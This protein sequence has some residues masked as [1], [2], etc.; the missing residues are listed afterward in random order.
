[1]SRAAQLATAGALLCGLAVLFA[2]SA[3]Y[4]PGVALLLVAVFA[5]VW[6]RLAAARASV[7]LDRAVASAYEGERIAVAICVRRG[8]LPFGPAELLVGELPV[9][10]PSGPE[11]A[12][13]TV[14]AIAARRGRQA[15]GPAR[16]R[17]GDPLGICVRELRSQEHELLVLPRVYPVGAGVLDR[18]QRGGSHAM[19]AD[20]QLHLDSLRA[21]DASGPASRIHWPT[22]ART[23]ELMSR[24]FAAEAD[25]RVLVVLDARVPA[26]ED[27]LD[28]ALRAAASLC[29]HLAR[30]GGCELLLPGES[31]PRAISPGLEG[32]P[33]LHAR[34]ALVRAG[35]QGANAARFRGGRTIVYVTAA[36][37]AGAVA[38]PCWRVGPHPLASV[39]VAFEVAGCAGQL[40]EDGTLRAAA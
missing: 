6:V 32:W 18:V 27:A 9:P 7:S 20:A 13:L 30:A 4:V 37:Q 35:T 21:Y 12:R 3:L 19:R 39:A 14:S 16:L 28:A 40:L 31:R 34:L 26:S 11:G 15:I 22:V 38:G 1:V 10:L 24:E 8:L 29:V 25:P 23:G 2:E 5:P 36:A 33:A 17:L